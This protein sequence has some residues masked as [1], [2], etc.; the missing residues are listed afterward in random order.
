MKKLLIAILV[1]TVPATAS[2]AP[3]GT[4]TDPKTG[5]SYTIKPDDIVT[6]RVVDNSNEGFT[7]AVTGEVTTDMRE[8]SSVW[9]I[10]WDE[11]QQRYKSGM[12]VWRE[13]GSPKI[14]GSCIRGGLK[15]TVYHYEQWL[16]P[17][18]HANGAHVQ[19][20]RPVATLDYTEWSVHGTPLRSSVDAINNATISVDQ[21]LRLYCEAFFSHGSMPNTPASIQ[22][23]C[24]AA[25]LDKCSAQYCEHK[26]DEA[27]REANL[28]TLEPSPM[29]DTKPVKA[30]RIAIPRL[31]KRCKS[32]RGTGVRSLRVSC[33]SARSVVSRY[34]RS[35]RSPKGWS[36]SAV[37]NDSQRRV[38]CSKR[39]KR[40]K[41]VKSQTV[42][43]LFRLERLAKN[44]R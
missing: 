32:V 43:G 24:T 9:G 11:D 8:C 20:M 10:K 12:E 15:S 36:C 1:L 18:A 29:A 25:G 44:A 16:F 27:D 39:N 23:A 5:A 4:I 21:A 41:V 42:Y 6:T 33:K 37:F 40:G 7:K 26:F 38:K 19:F 28:K 17:E 13:R 30:A 14:P 34:S 35:F 31:A 22:K 3:S 2:A